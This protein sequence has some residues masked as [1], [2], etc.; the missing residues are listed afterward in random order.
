MHGQADVVTQSEMILYH[1]RLMNVTKCSIVHTTICGQ[2][3]TLPE[4]PRSEQP[5]GVIQKAKYVALT[6][7]ITKISENI[8]AASR[9]NRCKGWRVTSQASSG[10]RHIVKKSCFS[11]TALNSGR[12]RPAWRMIQT[13]S[14]ET[15]SPRAALRMESFLSFGNSD[16]IFRCT[17]KLG[18][19]VFYLEPNCKV[20]K[21]TTRLQRNL[22]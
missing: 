2:G 14:G 1:I 18:R 4:K 3:H 21:L 12:Y 11:L 7:G 5:L 16:D 10:V 17:E 15:C 8:I 9:L 6:C 13:G 20:W 19:P 22:E